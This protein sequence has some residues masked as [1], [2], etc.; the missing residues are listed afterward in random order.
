MTNVL[1]SINQ[2]ILFFIVIILFYSI[3]FSSLTA[4]T[5]LSK[6]KSEPSNSTFKDNSLHVLELAASIYPSNVQGGPQSLPTIL[7]G[8]RIAS[9]L[10][11]ALENPNLIFQTGSS[12]RRSSYAPEFKYSHQFFDFFF[13][14]VFS[15]NNDLRREN[16][17]S[18]SN[19][20]ILTLDTIDAN[21]RETG[22]RAGFGPLDYLT[23][24]FSMEGYLEYSEINTRAP[25]QSYQA[26]IPTVQI[27]TSNIWDGYS[28]STG[29]MNYRI[30]K[31]TI[32]AGGSIAVW[33]DWL[34][35]YF[36]S[37]FTMYSGRLQLSSLSYENFTVSERIEESNE[38]NLVESRNQFSITEFKTGSR[39]MEDFWGINWFVELGFVIKLSDS[40]GFKYGGFFQTN[41]LTNFD[42]AS[43]F[44]WD[45]GSEP[46]LLETT[47]ILNTGLARS[48]SGLVFG[49]SFSI[50]KNF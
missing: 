2:L 44:K 24:D 28:F 49:Y 30:Q 37:E 29:K 6:S 17:S 23:D 38:I 47:P 16:Y 33:D 11:E 41:I 10:D 22:I 25:Y 8:T 5:S 50:V 45:Q 26:G 27:D 13:I 3:S 4:Q 34:N 14:G 15:K 46:I 19:R 21:I 42:R 31:V 20:G 7:N 35:V 12:R 18:F 43:G 1:K 32:G 39:F 40:I 9:P 36:T 48:D